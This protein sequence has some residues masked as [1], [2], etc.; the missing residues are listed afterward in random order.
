MSDLDPRAVLIAIEAAA[1]M[2][3]LSLLSFALTALFPLLRRFLSNS[4]VR[5]SLTTLVLAGAVATIDRWHPNPLAVLEVAA[6]LGAL[7]MLGIVLTQLI[8]SL[9]HPAAKWPPLM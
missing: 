3:G 4:F 5:F 2:V 1:L 8:P 6:L 7:G 9:R